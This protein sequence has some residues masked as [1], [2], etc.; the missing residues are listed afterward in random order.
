MDSDVKFI[1]R[2]LGDVKYKPALLKA[3]VYM[4]HDGD[5]IEILKTV[6]GFKVFQLVYEDLDLRRI[7]WQESGISLYDPTLDAVSPV[8][9]NIG[10]NIA[11]FHMLAGI[12]TEPETE[13]ASWWRRLLS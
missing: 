7:M 13:K 3:G 8:E 6:K 12:E 1:P 11:E 5:A 4:V 2:K 10:I 9:R